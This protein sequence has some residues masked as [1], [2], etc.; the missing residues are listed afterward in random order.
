MLELTCTTHASNGQVGFPHLSNHSMGS[1]VFLHTS[2]IIHK[3]GVYCG[4]ATATV[5]TMRYAH[6]QTNTNPLTTGTLQYLSPDYRPHPPPATTDV[7]AARLPLCGCHIHMS[8]YIY[9]H[10]NIHI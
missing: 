10:I 4:K 5:H 8:I 6:V 9:I 1:V 2:S 7:I 3:L